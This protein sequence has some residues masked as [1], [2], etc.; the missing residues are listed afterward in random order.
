MEFLILKFN[1]GRTAVASRFLPDVLDT[2][3]T[4]PIHGMALL[5]AL[6]YEDQ[7]R[8]EEIIPASESESQV[9]QFFVSWMK[10]GAASD[11][12][13]HPGGLGTK[14][15]MTSRVLGCK[16]VFEAEDD[17]LNPFSLPSRRLLPL[18]LRFATRLSWN[19]DAIS[20]KSMAVL[21]SGWRKMERFTRIRVLKTHSS[22]AMIRHSRTRCDPAAA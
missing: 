15:V 18:R 2:S 4:S 7:L 16:L 14:H 11:L 12:P 5:Y 20:L 21:N 13:S 17:E 9:V 1:A 3:S 8:G 6:G 10:Q 19:L 22:R